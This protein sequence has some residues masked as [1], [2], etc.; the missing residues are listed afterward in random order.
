MTFL[1]LEAAAAA[2]MVRPVATLPVNAILLMS[3]VVLSQLEWRDVRGDI[4]TH[5]GRDGSTSDGS[6]ARKA[7][8]NSGGEACLHDQVAEGESC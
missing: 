8:H 6:K 7:V 1:R 3:V 2:M 5:V 4:L